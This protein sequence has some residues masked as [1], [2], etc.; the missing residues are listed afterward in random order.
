MSLEEW[1]KADSLE[2]ADEY[3]K[4]YNYAV[5]NPV[6]RKILRMLD[7]GR[8]EEEIMQTLSLSKKQLDYHLKVLEAG[9]CI[10]RVGERWVVTDAGKIVDKIRG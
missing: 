5:T 4:R 7:K 3:H 1:I 10:E 6:R 8:S 9:F 2:K